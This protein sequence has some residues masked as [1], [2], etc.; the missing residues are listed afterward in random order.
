MSFAYEVKKELC[1]VP[2]EK[3][4]C[5]LAECYGFLLGCRNFSKQEIVLQSEHEEVA[6]RFCRLLK[7]VCGISVRV[8]SPA[9]AGGFYTVRLT[10]SFNCLT[11]LGAFGYTGDEPF[12]RINRGNFED[13]CCVC[14]FLRGAFCACGS[15]TDPNRDYHFE[16][17]VGKYHVAQDL[18][19]LMGEYLSRPKIT[20]RKSGYVV[21]YKE[22][23][24]IEDI[25]TYMQA[26]SSSMALMEVKIVK[27][28]RNKINR[29]TNCETANL[30]KSLEA[31]RRHLEAIATIEAL[32]SLDILPPEL[33]EIA[34]LR[35][36]N[37]EASLSELGSM[38]ESPLSRSGANH[39]LSKIV[40]IATK[41]K[42]QKEQGNS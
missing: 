27:D 14:A 26:V 2:E 24:K 42:T 40:D 7:E 15:I 25:L 34:L 29:A 37:P 41:V 16:L 5:L 17:S 35:R 22:S 12:V 10:E 21:Y 31:G 32:A 30:S 19:A 1:R 6:R 11:V 38:L 20:T 28:L 4:C 9:R 3:S 33:K 8:L 23:E 39:R 36:D 13:D 18:A